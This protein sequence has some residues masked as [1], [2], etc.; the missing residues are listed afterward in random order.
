MLFLPNLTWCWYRWV[1]RC[2]VIHQFM[3]QDQKIILSLGMSGGSLSFGHPKLPIP[4][5]P[6]RR[7]SWCKVKRAG[8]S[9]RR[10]Q[11]K[12]VMMM[13]MVMVMV[14][15]M[16]MIMIMMM[17]TEQGGFQPL[18]VSSAHVISD[19]SEQSPIELDPAD[20]SL[21]SSWNAGVAPLGWPV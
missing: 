17:I 3:A 18:E 9:L 10:G 21:L 8:Q 4:R 1:G 11:K 20:Y 15:M 2:S 5:W 16:M 13:V 14:M 19:W 6:V 12:M 7:R